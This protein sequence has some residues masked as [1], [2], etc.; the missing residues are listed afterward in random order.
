MRLRPSHKGSIEYS[1]C[2]LRVV[3]STFQPVSIELTP[4]GELWV[5]LPWSLASRNRGGFIHEVTWE[6]FGETGLN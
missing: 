3:D 1:Q 6:S 2:D 5:W 4:D